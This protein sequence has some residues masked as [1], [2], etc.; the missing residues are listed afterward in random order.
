MIAQARMAST[1]QGDLGNVK[2]MGIAKPVSP[3]LAP[4]GS[5]GPITPF[6]LEE[7]AEGGYLVAGARGEGAS[8]RGGER[9]MVGRMI[10]EELR[11]N[12]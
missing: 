9:E 1:A 5:P 11:R 7:S 3:R 12:T 2:V 8:G 6:E 4:L 10:S